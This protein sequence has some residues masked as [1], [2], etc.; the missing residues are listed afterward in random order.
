MPLRDLLQ[1]K[2]ACSELPSFFTSH[3]PF[4]P[5]DGLRRCMNV[6]K[7]T[8]ESITVFF[9]L[10][11]HFSI[12]ATVTVFL[13]AIHLY[14]LHYVHLN[15]SAK[16]V[17]SKDGRLWSTCSA[18]DE[19]FMQGDKQFPGE[20]PMYTKG[21][22]MLHIKTHP[23]CPHCCV[24][25]F[26]ESEIFT[27]MVETHL[28]CQP[29]LLVGIQQSYPTRQQLQEHIRYVTEISLAFEAHPAQ[30]A[31]PKPSS[32]ALQIG[33]MMMTRQRDMKISCTHEDESKRKGSERRCL[34]L[35]LTAHRQK[36]LEKHYLLLH[37]DLWEHTVKVLWSCGTPLREGSNFLSHRIGAAGIITMLAATRN[38]REPL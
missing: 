3:T 12:A 31:W 27:H 22:L 16:W 15:L 7:A 17:S 32:L 8:F 35:W 23:K 13:L 20:L 37:L 14:T 6:I 2:L 1:G 38:V 36:A 9:A 24:P 26:H 29:C 25:I 18:V 5:W 33:T 11:L 21:D 28:V 19:S 30:N 4:I 10:A 34:S